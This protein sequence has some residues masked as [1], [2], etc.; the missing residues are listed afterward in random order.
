MASL[1]EINWEKIFPSLIIIKS[2][3]LKKV[4]S[5]IQKSV[6][7]GQLRKNNLWLLEKVEYSPN[8]YSV[9]ILVSSLFK[10]FLNSSSEKN[11]KFVV[12]FVL[13]SGK[14]YIEL[15]VRLIL[16]LFD[17]FGGLIPDNVIISPPWIKRGKIS[18]GF[19]GEIK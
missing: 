4:V 18:S 19:W 10:F 14:P 1:S 8:S 11:G 9:N 7:E 17:F 3:W 15:I 13:I 2:L 6:S 16:I 5:K 12:L